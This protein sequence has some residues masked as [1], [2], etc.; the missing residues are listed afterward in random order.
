MRGRIRIRGPAP[1]EQRHPSGITTGLLPAG[2]DVTIEVLCPDGSWMPLE[3]VGHVVV[4]IHPGEAVTA[5][6]EALGVELVDMQAYAIEPESCPRC[7][8]SGRRGGDVEESGALV[9]NT[10][11]PPRC[12]TCKGSGLVSIQ[13]ARK[14]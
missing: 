14:G 9:T 12:H 8:G 2:E 11:F 10:L 5:R 3:S 1:T 6:F 4:N 13:P 7:K